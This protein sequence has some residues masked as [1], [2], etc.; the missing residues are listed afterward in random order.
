MIHG[1]GESPDTTIKAEEA[2]LGSQ[3]DDKDNLWVKV[4]LK[5]AK[6]D[7]GTWH[8]EVPDVYEIEIPL[9]DPDRQEEISPSWLPLWRIPGEIEKQEG[10]IEGCYEQY[11]A[12]A[13]YQMIGGDFATLGSDPLS[14]FSPRLGEMRKHLAKL[15]TEPY[16]RL[17]AG[18]SCLCFA[19]LGVPMAIWLRNRDLLTSFFLCFAPILIVYYPLW[20]FGIVEAKNGVVPPIAVWNGNVILIACGGWVLKRVLRY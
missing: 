6:I 5:R 19:W 15:R 2:E 16:R 18:F 1:H 3:Y 14:G 20:A 10:A 9:S 8:M 4:T 17:S 11:A 13:A 12:T 7:K